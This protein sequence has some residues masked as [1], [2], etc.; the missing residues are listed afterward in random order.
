MCVYVCAR[1]HVSRGALF[2]CCRPTCMVLAGSPY[3]CCYR[4]VF[5]CVVV[6]V[7]YSAFCLLA[8]FCTSC[9]LRLTSSHT[10]SLC[11]PLSRFR[12]Q[13]P[14]ALSCQAPHTGHVREHLTVPELSQSAFRRSLCLSTVS[15]N[16]HTR[17]LCLQKL[18]HA[19][20]ASLCLSTAS[21]NHHTLALP[22]HS[23]QKPPHARSAS[24]LS[25]RTI[26]RDHHTP[27]TRMALQSART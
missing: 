27:Q 6:L 19:R 4:L 16:H 13:S 15:K 8:C 17:S 21:R 5:L 1:C 18:P 7:L 23:L 26:T 20:S 3:A 9:M 2:C 11:A 25:P 24:P 12:P 10:V 22:L 14:G